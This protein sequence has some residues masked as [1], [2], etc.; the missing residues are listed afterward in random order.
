[1]IQGCKHKNKNNLLEDKKSK[2]LEAI[3]MGEKFV[4]RFPIA[5]EITSRN[6]K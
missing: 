1:M 5:Q 6:N 2:T 4:K 3:D